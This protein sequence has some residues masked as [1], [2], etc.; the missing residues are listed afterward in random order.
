MCTHAR[1]YDNDG[2]DDG[3]DCTHMRVILI[4]TVIVFDATVP[5]GAAS[6]YCSV[7]YTWR[8]CM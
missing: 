3:G 2:D 8:L 4:M 1:D 6:A 7:W 5:T